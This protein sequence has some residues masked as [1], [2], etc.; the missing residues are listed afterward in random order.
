MKEEEFEQFLD[1][2]MKLMEIRQSSKRATST[3]D[4][5]VAKK[6]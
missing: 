5:P 2:K 3:K 4:S 1:S 6:A